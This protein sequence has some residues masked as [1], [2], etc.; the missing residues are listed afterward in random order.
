[1]GIEK[2]IMV[3]TDG[4]LSENECIFNE[5]HQVLEKLFEHSTTED[6]KIK[7]ETYR[8]VTRLYRIHSSRI[9]K[10]CFKVILSP[11]KTSLVKGCGNLLHTVNSGERNVIG[12]HVKIT[13]GLVC[14]NWKNH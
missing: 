6:H 9:V 5:Y 3:S 13:Y 12:T 11:R 7:P 14:L 1:M 2:L 8:A 4:L 10:N